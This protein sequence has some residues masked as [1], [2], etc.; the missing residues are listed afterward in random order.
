MR[1]V[2]ESIWKNRNAHA[3]QIREYQETSGRLRRL[4]QSSIRLNILSN[5]MLALKNSSICYIVQ[6]SVNDSIFN[7]NISESRTF[8]SFFIGNVPLIKKIIQHTYIHTCCTRL[9]IYLSKKSTYLNL[10]MFD[11]RARHFRKMLAYIRVESLLVLLLQLSI[12]NIGIT[13]QYYAR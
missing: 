13:C 5:S 9:L 6:H 7:I 1:R 11:S 2:C 4:T 3:T 10:Y 8:S 12:Y